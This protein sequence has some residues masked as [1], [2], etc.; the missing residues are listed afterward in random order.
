MYDREYW[1]KERTCIMDAITNHMQNTPMSQ[2]DS[3]FLDK[4]F[5]E[6]KV[7]L[8]WSTTKFEVLVNYVRNRF[9]NEP[10]YWKNCYIGDLAYVIY[11]WVRDNRSKSL[12]NKKL[13]GVKRD[14]KV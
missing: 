8:G 1:D 13:K 9:N 5:R 6:N 7:Q 3:D 2:R 4:V 10:D 11:E 14:R 12:K